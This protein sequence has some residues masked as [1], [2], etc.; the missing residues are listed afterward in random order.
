MSPLVFLAIP[1]VVFVL[2][3]TVLWLGS[4]VRGGDSVLRQAPHDLRAVAPML[5]DQRDAG[6][7]VGAGSRDYRG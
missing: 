3:S 6:W 5:R 7:R 4:R 1:V 2:G